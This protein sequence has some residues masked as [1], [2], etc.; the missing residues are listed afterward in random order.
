[1]SPET[2]PE[3]GVPAWVTIVGYFSLL[4]L[5]QR[6]KQ[7]IPAMGILLIAPV[8]FTVCFVIRLPV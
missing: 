3:G 4:G 2:P 6:T 5:A 1:M 8:N 7:A